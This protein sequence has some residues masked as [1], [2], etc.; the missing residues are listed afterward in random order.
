MTRVRSHVVEFGLT[1]P[2]ARQRAL[3]NTAGSVALV[4]LAGYVVAYLLRPE[5]VPVDFHVYRQA[6]EEIA[7][8]ESPYP[9]FAY[10]PLSALGALPFTFL[11]TAAA[12]FAIKALLVAG[13]LGVL[14][15]AG[16]RDWR[17][18]PLALL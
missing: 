3:A 10:P 4:V 13:V 8:G 9:W 5:V 14:A 2:G 18:Y 17:C 1:A 11:S 15:L 7:A 16:V 12:D 6:A